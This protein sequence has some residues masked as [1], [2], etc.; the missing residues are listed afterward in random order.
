V[1]VA[2][3]EPAIWLW[4]GGRGDVN[5]RDLISG[6][7]THGEAGRHMVEAVRITQ[8]SP[9]TMVSVAR[10]TIKPN[11][12]GDPEAGRAK[13]VADSRVVLMTQGQ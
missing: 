12:L 7:P 10:G 11:R 13:R 4:E 1:Y 2:N 5:T 6:E 9:T 8:G 3:S